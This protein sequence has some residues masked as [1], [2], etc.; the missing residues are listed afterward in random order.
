MGTKWRPS[1]SEIAHSS[2]G[3]L[4]Q[5]SGFCEIPAP[6]AVTYLMSQEPPA[7]ISELLRLRKPHLKIQHASFDHMAGL[8]SLPHEIVILIYA[9]CPDIPTAIRLSAVDQVRRLIWLDNCERIIKTILG[10]GIPAFDEALDLAKI[11]TQVLDTRAT[12]PAPT[13]NK[14]VES[15][16]DAEADHLRRQSHLWL[17][18]LLRDLEMASRAC[19][20]NA[21]WQDQNETRRKA[22]FTPWPVSYYF[23]RRLVTSYHSADLRNILLLQLETCSTDVLHTHHELC[24]FMVTSMSHEEQT[25]HWIPKSLEELTLDDTLNN[26]DSQPDWEQAYDLIFEAWQR[27]GCRKLLN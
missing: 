6:S 4:A 10:S 18:R 3:Q 9:S 19:A 15:Q 25:R 20:E 17:P 27:R 24:G 23:I 7:P 12:T 2:E 1:S 14:S 13:S 11:G 16:N 21:V 26:N 8:T 22:T 5:C